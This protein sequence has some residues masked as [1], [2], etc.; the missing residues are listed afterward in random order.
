MMPI[1]TKSLSVVQV[2]VYIGAALMFLFVALLFGAQIFPFSSAK[3]VEAELARQEDQQEC[4]GDD[5][6]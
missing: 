1:L 5:S 6:G 3:K 4:I 2:A